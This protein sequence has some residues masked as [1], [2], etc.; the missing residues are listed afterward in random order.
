MPRVHMQN[1]LNIIKST[2][3][4]LSSNK[5]LGYITTAKI[6]D[7]SWRGTSENFSLNWQEQIFLYERLVPSTWN[8]P[9]EQKL[10]MLQMAVHPIQEFHQ[11]KATA[12][13]LKFPTRKDLD[14]EEYSALLLS[15]ASDYDIKVKERYIH[16]I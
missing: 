12:M 15:T 8:F 13:L 5:I 16:M 10:T 2:K 3:A 7:A 4:S 6:G 14:Y 1:C 9:D 11:V